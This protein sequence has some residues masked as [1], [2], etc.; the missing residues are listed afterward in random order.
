MSSENSKGSIVCI[1]NYRGIGGAQ[2]N[3]SLMAE[4][5]E[6]RGFKAQV[7]FLCDREKG[8]FPSGNFRVLLEDKKIGIINIWILL[9]R[10]L[11]IFHHVK[12]VAVYGFQPA[13]N[14]F[15]AITSKIVASPKFIATQRN[16]SDKQSKIGRLL[17][18]FI[19]SSSL[20]DSNIAVSNAVKESYAEHGRKYYEKMLTI[21]N[22]TP[23]LEATPVSKTEARAKFSMPEGALI[24]GVV[25]RL[26]KQKN[27][28]FAISI[29]EKMP[30]AFLYVAGDGPEEEDLK[31]YCK[32]KNVENRVNFLGSIRGVQLTEFYRAMDIFLLTSVYEGF[33]RTIVEALSQGLPVV[34]NDIPIAREVAGPAGRYAVLDVDVWREAILAACSDHDPAAAVARAGEFSIDRMAASYLEAAKLSD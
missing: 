34:A 15:G 8:Y 22:G 12:P 30:Q 18:K 11:K 20:Y 29:L 16:P 1:C 2:M 28:K 26:H 13:A 25:A 32:E 21:H 4:E 19:G 27:I 23:V 7:V 17:D 31:N 5:F 24:L 3:A 6:K 33:G 10:L 9:Y 14:A